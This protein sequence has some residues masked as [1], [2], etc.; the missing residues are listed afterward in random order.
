MKNIMWACSFADWKKE[1]WEGGTNV[2]QSAGE[3]KSLSGFTAAGK[4]GSKRVTRC[5]AFTSADG[6]V[7][8]STWPRM[9][10]KQLARNSQAIVSRLST[11]ERSR[12]LHTIQET[13]R[14]LAETIKQTNKLR[15]FG[16]ASG[17]FS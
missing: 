4:L 10:T 11:L 6:P 17:K 7:W 5:V 1:L 14:A 3:V 13:T 2:S 12:T 8:L 16:E 15:T 9:L